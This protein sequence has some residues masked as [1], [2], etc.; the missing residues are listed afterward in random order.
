MSL[1]AVGGIGLAFRGRTARGSVSWGRVIAGVGYPVRNAGGQA[2]TRHLP[3]SAEPSA[4]LADTP[5]KGGEVRDRLLGLRGRSHALLGAGDLGWS[6]PGIARPSNA[7][8]QKAVPA[9]SASPPH[10]TVAYCS[11]RSPG[12]RRHPS[13]PLKRAGRGLRLADQQGLDVGDRAPGHFLGDCAHQPPLGF[14]VQLL[15]DAAERLGRAMIASA[16]K[17][18]RSAAC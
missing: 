15:A 10:A 13:F 5:L 14:L 4:S 6:G 18:L 17:S 11:P 16:S 7:G 9:F 2:M 8:T 1:A 12:R 3:A